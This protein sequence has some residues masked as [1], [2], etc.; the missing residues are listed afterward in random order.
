MSDGVE[1]KFNYRNFTSRNC[2]FIDNKLQGRMRRARLVFAGCGL[3]SIIAH[4]AVRLGFENLVL[5][6]G[7][8][9]ELSNLNRQNFYLKDIGI[10][11]AIVTKQILGWLNP[12]IRVQAY[13]CNLTNSNLKKIISDS[14]IV[15]NTIDVNNT[16]YNIIE[17]SLKLGS[18]VI[19]PFN[20]GFGGV[21][22]V[23]NEKSIHPKQVWPGGILNE[24]DFYKGFLDAAQGYQLPN[25]VKG[26]ISGLVKRSRERG[27]YPQTIIGAQVISSITLT[28]ILSII[29]G[30]SIPIFPNVIS[31]DCRSKII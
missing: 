31:H 11:K 3:N 24:Q 1:Q 23:F 7:D 29:S 28:I 16:Y 5:V 27:F 22:A 19:C 21:V 4:S 9:V 14:D 15:I 26:G 13:D 17:C 20:V 6:D 2:E 25:Y 10:N 12:N 8:V 30:E 18:V